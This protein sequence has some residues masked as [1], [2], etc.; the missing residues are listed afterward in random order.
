[1]L[2][3]EREEVAAAA[4]RLADEGLVLGTS[5]NVS[6]R[7]GEFVAITATGAE[8][9]TVD[10]DQVTVVG[11]NGVAIDGP[12]APSSELLMHTAVYERLDAT[13]VVH[14]H[15]PVATALAC[16]LSELPVVH[17]Q[18]LLL[19]GA[20]RVAPYATFGSPELAELTVTALRGRHASL[21]SGHGAITVGDDLAAAI[22]RA[23]LLEWICTVYWRAAS[24]GQPRLL[25]DDEQARALATLQ[26]GHGVRQ[27]AR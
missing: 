16:V 5:G 24:I 27:Q 21:M 6:R 12:Y 7:C 17:Y 8:L 1:M 25:T 13:A 23:V 9:A 15:P 10:A 18:Q 14:T 2:E 3:R 20:I 26:G 22:D 19:G 4:R 11:L